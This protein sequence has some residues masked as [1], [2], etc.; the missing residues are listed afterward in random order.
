MLFDQQRTLGDVIVITASRS[1]ARWAGTVAHVATPLGTR[2]ELTPVVLRVGPEDCERLL[3]KAHPE[4]AIIATWAMAHRHGSAAKKVVKRALGV[5]GK[6]P[7]ELQEAQRNAIFTLL[8]AR[9]MAWLKETRMNLTK[10]PMSEAALK[11]KE[12]MQADGRAEGKRQALLV[13]LH[14]RGLA[15]TAEERGTIEGCADP[16][17]LDRWL[18]KAGTAASASEVLVPEKKAP[19]K[20]SRART[21]KR[22]AKRLAA[23][24]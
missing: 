14:G 8:S 3:S 15:V 19:A 12:E 21:A 1:V 17:T 13:V 4:L 11:F 22:S 9:M 10:I 20:R 2:L 18:A 7:A 16:A 23:R 24:A 5:T 6:L